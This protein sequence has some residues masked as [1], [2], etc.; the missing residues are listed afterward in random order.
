MRN[1]VSALRILLC[2]LPIVLFCTASGRLMLPLAV[3]VFIHE[4]AHLLALRLARGRLRGFCAAPL[5]LR[6]EID[7]STLSNRG[8]ALVT[9]AGSAANLI[10]F[11]LAL[12]LRRFLDCDIMTFGVVSLLSAA[13]NLLP[14]EPLDGGRLLYLLLARHTDPLRAA[15]IA[16]GVSFLC[17]LL[18]FLFS[19]YSTLTGGQGLYSIVFSLYILLATARG[20]GVVYPSKKEDN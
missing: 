17:A 3:A 13:L 19:S 15:R 6:L 20:A 5:G 10:C 8:E 7:E 11:L 4:S 9:A 1:L 14:A 12:V 2:A 16:S 18:I